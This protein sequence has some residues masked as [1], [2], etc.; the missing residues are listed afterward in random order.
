MELDPFN[1]LQFIALPILTE[2]QTVPDLSS[3]SPFRLAVGSP[4][5]STSFDR[6]PPCSLTQQNNPGSSCTYPPQP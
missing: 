5:H 1:M 6:V 2:A 4:E 3:G